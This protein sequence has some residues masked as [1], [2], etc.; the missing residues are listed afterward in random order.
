[1]TIFAGI[2]QFERSLII[3]RTSRGR[4][5]AKE[6]GVKFGRPVKHNPALITLI[7]RSIAE[8]SSIKE[9][10]RTHGVHPATIYR[11]TEKERRSRQTKIIVA[12]DA[13]HIK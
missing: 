4:Q 5:A 3:E 13:D 2:A 10:A 12:A 9:T 8:G 6:R 11:W 1:M 7:L